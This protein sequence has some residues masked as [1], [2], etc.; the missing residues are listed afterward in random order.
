[1]TKKIKIVIYILE[2]F[3]LLINIPDIINVL[4]NSSNYPFHSQ[5]FKY[6]NFDV[7]SRYSYDIYHSKETYITHC[8]VNIILAS[9]VIYLGVNNKMKLFYISTI[10]SILF[11][12]VPMLTIE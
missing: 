6:N 7:F 9:F 12:L 3:I 1:M 10:I 4:I 8:I 11:L 2:A 5:G